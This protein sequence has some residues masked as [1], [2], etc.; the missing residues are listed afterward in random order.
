MRWVL[1]IVGGVLALA[2]I[3]AL[4]GALLPQSHVASRSR[5]FAQPAE[6]VFAAIADVRDYPRWRPG[7]R[8]VT[9]LSQSPLR[10]RE[11]GS[12]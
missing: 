11:D 7:V 5:S 2:A 12:N 6:R 10:W 8:E 1:I 9:V 3:V 4:V